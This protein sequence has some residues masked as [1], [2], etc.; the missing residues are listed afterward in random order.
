MRDEWS[1]ARLHAVKGR[2]VH[3]GDTAMEET[4][5]V[6]FSLDE[7]W[8]MQA[9]I[10]HECPQAEQWKFPPA[11]LG[12]N[13]SI[14]AAI[15]L[16]EEQDQQEAALL[17]GRHD[18]LVIDFN[19]P[20]NAK[21]ANGKPVGK[22]VLLKSFQSRRQLEDGLEISSDAGPEMDAQTIRDRLAEQ[23]RRGRSGDYA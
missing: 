20:A 16:C 18:C 8:L 22:A 2:A 9:C 3:M 7:L 4:V 15:L 19:V 5:S 21:D 17:V 10:R 12:L 13:D 11:S 14:A 1:C 6:V 23:S